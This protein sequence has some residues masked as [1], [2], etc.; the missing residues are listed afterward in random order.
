[1]YHAQVSVKRVGVVV[2]VRKLVHQRK[3]RG[4]PSLIHGQSFMLR[5]ISH[6]LGIQYDTKALF[7]EA[8]TTTPNE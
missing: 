1:M 2:S 5:Q 4:M 6:M 3:D 7:V 8:L